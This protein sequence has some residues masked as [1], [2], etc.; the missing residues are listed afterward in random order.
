M[1]KDLY[2]CYCYSFEFTYGV[3]GD[4]PVGV[5]LGLIRTGVEG[6][7]KCFS[8]GVELVV[9]VLLMKSVFVGVRTGNFGWQR[10]LIINYL[11]SPGPVSA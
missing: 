10:F 2:V 11:Y 1:F 9:V 7:P 6:C 5:G 8:L 3:F 4:D